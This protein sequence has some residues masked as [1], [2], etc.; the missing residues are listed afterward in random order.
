VALYLFFDPAQ[1]ALNHAVLARE[2][3]DLEKRTITLMKT[4]ALLHELMKQRIEIEK[5]EPP[6]LT[7]LNAICYNET[8][9]GKG[10]S[11]GEMVRISW[12]QRLFSPFFD[13]C[14]SGLK[15]NRD[16]AKVEA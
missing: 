11:N 15:K 1:R 16:A 4:E 10:H 2:F 7:V 8:A 13:I 9:R 14:S 6:I 5:K 12:I 3:Y